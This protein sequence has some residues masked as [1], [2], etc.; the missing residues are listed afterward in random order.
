MKKV[1]FGI[2]GLGDRGY[3]MLRDVIAD[4]K[5]VEVIAVSDYFPDRIENAI[6]LVK[7]KSGVDAK[8]Y[9]NYLD[10]LK[11]ENVEAVY[12]ATSWQT[13]AEVAIACMEHGKIAGNRGGRSKFC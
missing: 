13:H 10:L 5:D 1:K 8:G 12:V 3:G 9:G 2:I 7:E 11:D 4:M 6:K